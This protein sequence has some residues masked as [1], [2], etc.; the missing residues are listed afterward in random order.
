MCF[1]KYDG[2]TYAAISQN[3]EQAVKSASSAIFAA[4][5]E[6]YINKGG[7][8]FSAAFDEKRGVSHQNINKTEN[9]YLL[10]KFK[11]VQNKISNTYKETKELLTVEEK[12][13]FS[14]TLC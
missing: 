1:L 12:G 3:K 14:G 5:A 8:V 13:F 4:L 9:L 7:N 10:Q 11:Y 2:N 6:D